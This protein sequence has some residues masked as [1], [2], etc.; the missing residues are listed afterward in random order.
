MDA[1]GAE[2]DILL[3]VEVEPLPPK[4]KTRKKKTVEVPSGPE[5]S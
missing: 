3:G 1:L 2:I 4:K 5:D